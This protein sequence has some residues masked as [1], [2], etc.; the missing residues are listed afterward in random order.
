MCHQLELQGRAPGFNADAAVTNGTQKKSSCLL[1]GVLGGRH[2]GQLAGE[3]PFAASAGSAHH[4]AATAQGGMGDM[5]P[6]CPR[7]KFGQQ[8]SQARQRSAEHASE[9][10]LRSLCSAA[11]CYDM[12]PHRNLPA[13][14]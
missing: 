10:H 1:V 12:Q 9:Q 7:P 3:H 5:A 6:S 11:G 14:F 13:R 2:S 8:S 4:R